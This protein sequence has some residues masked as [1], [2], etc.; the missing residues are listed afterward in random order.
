MAQMTI[1]AEPSYRR[2]VYTGLKG[3][4]FSADP[5]LVDSRHSPDALNMISDN[6]GDYFTFMDTYFDYNGITGI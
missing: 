2:K 6:G 4:N 3:V 1:P 5:S